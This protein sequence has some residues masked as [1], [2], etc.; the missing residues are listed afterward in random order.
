MKSL[1][2]CAAYA[3]LCSALCAQ[4]PA[5]APE[6]VLPSAVY[7]W[8]KLLA[9]PFSGGER[10]AVLEGHTTSLDKL[11][12]HIT[13]LKPGAFNGDQPSRHPQEEVLLIKE[14]LVE[15]N[16]DGRLQTV[17]P[18][19]VLY[20]ASNATTRYRNVGDTPAT[21]FVVVYYTPL[22]PKP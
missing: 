21:Y 12:C 3:A 6:A 2:C 4:T 13:T 10:R 5:K 15:A 1:A 11:H 14:G 22:T 19:S 9:V 16:I 7:D 17:G 8:T 18:G 20:I